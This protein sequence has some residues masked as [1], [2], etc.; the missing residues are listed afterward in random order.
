MCII[1]WN[2]FLI[3]NIVVN[4]IKIVFAHLMEALYQDLCPA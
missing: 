3:L 4:N 2:L 1:Y